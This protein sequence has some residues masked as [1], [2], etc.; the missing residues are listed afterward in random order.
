MRF[1]L[2]ECKLYVCLGFLIIII[3]LGSNWIDN[4]V[5]T[6]R[7]AWTYWGIPSSFFEIGV[8]Y[9]PRACGSRSILN[10]NF[11]EFRWYFPIRPRQTHSILSIL[12]L[13]IP[14]STC[15]IGNV[16]MKHISALKGSW[17]LN[18]GTKFHTSSNVVLYFVRNKYSLL[19]LVLF[20]LKEGIT[21]LG[22]ELNLF[23]LSY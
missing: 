14:F 21:N 1:Y 16:K 10:P 17:F 4:N 3:V 13:R 2:V 8:Q 5:N 12:T 11:S 6:V 23:F 18:L 22:K 7:L 15:F 20:P 19:R 9:G